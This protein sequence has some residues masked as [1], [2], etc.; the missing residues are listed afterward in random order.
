MSFIVKNTTFPSPL[1]LLAPHY[2]RGCGRLGEPLC[3]RC[4]KYIIDNHINLCPNSKTK[5]K[6]GKCQRCKTIPPVYSI[7][8]REDLLNTL[9]H[10][11]K[12]D[13]T[14][15]IGKEFAAILN[16]ILPDINN[17]IIVPLPTSTKHIRTRGFDHTL[18]VAKHLA[19]LRH[20]QIRKPLLRAKNT[21]Q[22]GANQKT[23]LS[24][25][26]NAYSLNP[27][28]KVSPDPTYIIFDDVWTT[29]ASMRAAT[30]ILQQAGAKKII[31][32]L[33]AISRIRD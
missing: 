14:R 3:D 7:G 18:F 20:Y 19:H 17:A 26:K 30:K 1:D 2:C 8:P 9:I 27:K 10:H 22:V 33:L 21:V 23:R 29:G 25:A 28:I 6:N 15:T 13:S 11:Y 4:K 16:S 5:T 24:Q 31:I 12:Y 32:A